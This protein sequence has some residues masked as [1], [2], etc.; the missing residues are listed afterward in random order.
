MVARFS[1]LLYLP[2]EDRVPVNKS[3]SDMVKFASAEDPTYRTVLRY[4]KEWVES[5]TESYGI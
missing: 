1:A 4:L 2:P 5:I 3:H